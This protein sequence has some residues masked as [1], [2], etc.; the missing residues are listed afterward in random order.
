[1]KRISLFLA[2]IAISF[3]MIA[4][5]GGG[6]GTVAVVP[7]SQTVPIVGV[8]Y[9]SPTYAALSEEKSAYDV[10]NTARKTCGFGYL[11]QN[12]SLDTAASNHIAWNVYNSL[13]GHT[14]TLGTLG[15]TG[16]D[17]AQRMQSAGYANG[18][19]YGEVLTAVPSIGTTGLGQ[20]GSTTLLAAPYHLIGLMSGNREVGISVRSGGDLGS[21]ADVMYAGSPPFSQLVVDMASST[22]NLPQQQGASDVLTYPC[23]GVTNTAKSVTN[24]TP[25]PILYR[26]LAVQ[27]IGQPVFVQVQAGRTLVITSSSISTT[28][29]SNPVVIATTLTKANDPASELAGN[30]AMII[31]DVPLVANTQYT[32]TIQGTNNGEVFLKNFTFTTGN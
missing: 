13:F 16:A 14:E 21:G 6:A 3:T 20:S 28:V 17:P 18:V 29:G 15:F 32:V 9:A 31:P 2:T 22:S 23:Q 25:N 1:M 24:E 27:P 12:V 26:Q 5:G 19:L 30:Q 10:N 11:K 8:A 4:C 7:D